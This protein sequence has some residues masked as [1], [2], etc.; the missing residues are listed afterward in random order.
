MRLAAAQAPHNGWA[1]GSY[2]SA[3]SDVPEAVATRV[4]APP[5]QALKPWRPRGR[6]HPALIAATAR[7]ARAVSCPEA[8]D[9]YRHEDRNEEEDGRA[10]DERGL[11]CLQF[12]FRLVKVGHPVQH[13]I[14]AA[15]R[16]A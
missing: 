13:L 11:T 4:R 16:F 1:E 9:G 6:T 15:G 8:D 3:T 5:K 14:Q 12:T 2:V 10:E 7:N